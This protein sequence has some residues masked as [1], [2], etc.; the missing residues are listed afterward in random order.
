MMRSKRPGRVRAVS[1]VAGLLVAAITMTPVLSSKPSISVKSWLMVCTLSAP[2]YAKRQPFACARALKL[3]IAI[4][5][6]MFQ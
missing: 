6:L 3:V 2:P 1:R 5:R 4:D